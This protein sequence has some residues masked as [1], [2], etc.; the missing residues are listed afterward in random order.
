MKK[1]V[2]V[3]RLPTKDKVGIGGIYKCIKEVDYDSD[4]KLNDL[5]INR[6]SLVNSTR[7]WDT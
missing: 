2:Q 1:L 6:N 7:L 3:C 5:V 4:N